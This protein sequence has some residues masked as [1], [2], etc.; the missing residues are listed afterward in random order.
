MASGGQAG[1]GRLPEGSFVF[2]SYSHADG[3]AAKTVVEGLERAGFTG[4]WLQASPAP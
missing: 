2:V 3:R 1:T 4:G